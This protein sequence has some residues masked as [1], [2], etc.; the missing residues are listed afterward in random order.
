MDC[1]EIFHDD[2]AL[3]NP[4]FLDFLEQWPRPLGALLDHREGNAIGAAFLKRLQSDAHGRSVLIDI[5]HNSWGVL[6][7]LWKFPH[8]PPLFLNLLKELETRFLLLKRRNLADQVISFHLATRTELWHE[9]LTPEMVAAQLAPHEIPTVRA[10][11]LCGLFLRA[12]ALVAEFLGPY[13]YQRT[14]TYEDAFSGDS[15]TAEAAAE[16]ER[17][18]G[19]KV[20]TN[21]LPLQRNRVDK[22][23]I[24]SNYDEVCA[25][26]EQV[27]RELA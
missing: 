3:A 19:L 8:E 24:I 13:F 7:P 17:F 1:G 12:E 26:A 5:K 18:T 11:E 21:P 27:R 2:R 4:P 10:R 23:Q 6:R 14:I 16:I 20:D 15:V 22:R 9:T 25:I